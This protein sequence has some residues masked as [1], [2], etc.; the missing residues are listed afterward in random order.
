[1][2]YSYVWLHLPSSMRNAKHFKQQSNLF[3]LSSCSLWRYRGFYLLF[4]T[5][6]HCQETL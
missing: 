2:L 4:L 1:V 5:G 3:C 6:E